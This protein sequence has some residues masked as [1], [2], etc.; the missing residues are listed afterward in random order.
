MGASKWN[1]QLEQWTKTDNEYIKF[2]DT[3]PDDHGKYNIRTNFNEM[4]QMWMIKLSST[5]IRSNLKQK[6]D[7]KKACLEMIS[8][9]FPSTEL[10]TN[11]LYNN[12]SYPFE[13]SE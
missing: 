1:V 6:N 9:I 11:K 12:H 2:S 7:F 5:T 8:I 3:I 13:Q 10:N 4:S